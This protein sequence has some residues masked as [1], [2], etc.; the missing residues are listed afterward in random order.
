MDW[1]G[2]E[3]SAGDLLRRHRLAAGLTQ[4][5]LASRAGL[6]VRTIRDIESDRARRPRAASV[7]R[8]LAALALGAGECGEVLTALTDGA[9]PALPRLRIGVLGPLTVQRNGV[10]LDVGP[11]MVRGLLG[12]LALQPGTV[13]ARDDI[14]DVLWGQRPPKTSA[15]LTQ[16]YVARLRAAL[17]DV[18][19]GRPAGYVVSRVRN[20]YRLDLSSDG[21]DL[22]YFDSLVRQ[23][24]KA[25]AAGDFDGALRR[26]RA[27]LGCW[28]G[29]VL[30]DLGAQLRQHPAAVAAMRRRASAVTAYA[31]LAIASDLPH[32]A[33]DQL[34]PLCADEP[35]NEGLHARL[36]VALAAAGEQAAALRSYDDMRRRLDEEL[37]VEPGT[38]LREAHVHV[39]RS[40]SSDRTVIRPPAPAADSAR[41]VP[42]ELPTDIAG[43]TGRPAHLQRLDALLSAA[44]TSGG[45]TTGALWDELGIDPGPELQDVH[46]LVPSG[47]P[48]SRGVEVTPV[49]SL[50]RP[51]RDFTGRSALIKELLRDL[52]AAPSEPIVRSIDGMAGV[53]KTS[54]ALHVARLVG[55]RFPDAHLFIDLHGHGDRAA[56]STGAALLAL[57]RQ[58]EIPV[59]QIPPD[60]DDRVALW[61]S[62]LARRRTVLLLDNAASSAQVAPLL[63]G[64]GINLTLITSRRRLAGLDAVCATS[65]P[66]LTPDEASAVFAAVVGERAAAEP[67]AVAEVVRLCGALPLAVRVAAARMTLRPNWRVSDLVNRLR[68]RVLPELAAEDRAVAAAFSTTYLTLSGPLRRLFRLLGVYPGERIDPAA[69]AALADIGMAEAEDG[70]DALH[71]VHLLEA[72][73]GAYR[74]HDLIHQYAASLAAADPDE[75]RAAATR[76]LDHAVH[77][78]AT[79]ALQVESP[80]SRL[81]RRL[82]EP[83]RPD[84]LPDPATEAA[85]WFDQYRHDHM[86]L[87]RLAEKLNAAE[88]VWK[89]A[90]A[91]WRLWYLYAQF[92]DIVDA[93]RRGLRAARSIPDELA[94]AVMANY[95]ASGLHR[96]GKVR[97][98]VAVLSD[99]LRLS[100]EQR[101]AVAIDVVLR[102]NL[103]HTLLGVGDINAATESAFEALRLARRDRDPRYLAQALNAVGSM[104][105]AQGA[106][107]ESLG[108]HRREL[109]AAVTSGVAVGVVNALNNVA[110][111][112]MRLGHPPARRLLTLAVALNR[113]IGSW[114]GLAEVTSALAVLHRTEGDHASAVARHREAVDIARSL[115]APGLLAAVHNDFAETMVAAADLAAAADLFQEAHRLARQA[116]ARDEEARSLEGL[117]LTATDRSTMHHYLVHALTIYRQID[118]PIHVR[119]VEQRLKTAL[120]P[121]HADRAD[122]SLLARA[123]GGK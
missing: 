54:L 83:L 113:R 123:A 94:A 41:P 81:N 5:E 15:N 92:D 13:V 34:R 26:Y 89:L 37:G 12:L 119:R 66:V 106:L 28:R 49:R 38:Q 21:V 22:S 40:G 64:S 79:V 67:G 85:R 25:A 75:H 71:A 46:R 61:R 88:Y 115:S 8:M 69:A 50:P 4:R 70:L 68:D 112:R 62:A 3:S 73:D 90:R 95:L 65:L 104:R 32:L 24:G 109:L 74:L 36:M 84:L 102:A 45:A 9:S 27:A 86:A 77:R 105:A 33:I 100:A 29:P 59:Q 99:V 108:W 23:A 6:A 16:V 39:L 114:L 52:D 20:G 97:E 56:L 42:A 11:R 35:L 19:A 17:M 91:A 43:F 58:L 98:A 78:A 82:G 118:V 116:E 60:I 10:D 120:P 80:Q 96:L 87:L 31:D 53:G 7:R 1:N 57:L 63:P 47:D 111:I 18:G 117:A 2:Q 121:A 107:V 14:V 30:A 110:V 44:A 93:H 122:G 76:L 101:R 103:A 72:T 51:V 48:S 55:D